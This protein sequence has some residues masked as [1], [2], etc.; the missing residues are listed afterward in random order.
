[1]NTFIKK[2]FKYF[3]LMFLLS[4]FLNILYLSVPLYVMAVHDKVLF[5]FS[6][7]SLIS[8]TVGL[9][10][11][12]VFYFIIDFSKKYLM[13]RASGYLDT[14]IAPKCAGQMMS[15]ENGADSEY[16]RGL[17]DLRLLRDVLSGGKVIN[18]FDSPWIIIFFAVLLYFF[19]F[20]NGIESMKT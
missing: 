8:L 1:M 2:V 9:F 13:V 7:Q 3:I 4:I 6:F 11:A 14:E 5:S 20:N 19:S 16:K 17:T 10:I 15:P 12:L 18:Y